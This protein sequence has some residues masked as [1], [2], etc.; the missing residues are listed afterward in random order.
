MSKTRRKPIKYYSP[1][2][3]AVYARGDDIDAL[4]L[5]DMH[6]WVCHLCDNTIGRNYRCPDW[7]AAT[8]DHVVPLCEGGLHV[9]ENVKPAHLS[10]NL[11]KGGGRQAY[12]EGATLV[13]RRRP[14]P[15]VSLVQ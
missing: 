2:R 4:T 1:K 8:I 6:N 3:R 13:F 15:G 9:W 7:R 5:F 12:P 11:S 14:K 10:C